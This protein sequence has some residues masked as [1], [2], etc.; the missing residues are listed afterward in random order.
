MPSYTCSYTHAAFLYPLCLLITVQATYLLIPALPCY[1]QREGMG[2]LETRP[3]LPCGWLCTFINKFW[4]KIRHF[5]YNS[6][7]K[8]HQLATGQLLSGRPVRYGKGRRYAHLSSTK[9]HLPGHSP[10]ASHSLWRAAVLGQHSS[11][12]SLGGGGGDKSGKKKT[13]VRIHLI[14]FRVRKIF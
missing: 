9:S 10:P 8:F 13:I 7:W 4:Y 6:S 11:L 1:T 2:Q 12:R 3:C 14:C 5:L